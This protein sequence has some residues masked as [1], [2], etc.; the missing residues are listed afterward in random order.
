MKNLATKFIAGALL[1][2][3]VFVLAGCNQEDA[4]DADS[5]VSDNEA[6][7]KSDVGSQEIELIAIEGYG[8]P[9]TKL[10]NGFVE[11]P[12][13]PT[14]EDK[15]YYIVEDICGQFT[16]AFV[17]NMSKMKIEKTEPFPSS[18]NG[19]YGCN[20]YP[21]GSD[22]S[23]SIGLHYADIATQKK[24]QEVLGRKVTSDEGMAM[25]NYVVTQ[26]DGLINEIY[27]A[28]GPNKFLS[29]NRQSGSDVSEDTWLNFVR[30]TSRAIEDYK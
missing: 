29:F 13:E 18:L 4:T 27:L 9:G 14:R 11:Y 15:S 5:V 17:E 1:L 6:D 30:Q 23:F 19:P 24:G 8:E 26:S 20:Y 10:A 28:L 12:G 3:L 21:A 16:P 22:K 7:Q 2:A 25:E